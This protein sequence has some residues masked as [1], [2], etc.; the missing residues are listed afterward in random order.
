[1]EAV[2]GRPSLWHN[3]LSAGTIG[4]IGVRAGRFGVPFVNPMVLQYQYG[5]RPEVAAFGVYG[6]I[7]GLLAGLIGGKPF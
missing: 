3:I 1:M 6:G 5:I 2:H 7:A 4:F